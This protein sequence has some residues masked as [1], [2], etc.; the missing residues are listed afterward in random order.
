MVNDVTRFLRHL[1][2]ANVVHALRYEFGR[3]GDELFQLIL[4]VVVQEVLQGGLHRLK[5]GVLELMQVLHILLLQLTV[6]ATV[7]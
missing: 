2:V 1:H 4:V 5:R 6:D 3:F 7:L